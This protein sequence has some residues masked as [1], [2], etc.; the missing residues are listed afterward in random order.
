[1]P[2]N[3]DEVGLIRYKPKDLLNYT[4]GVFEDLKTAISFKSEINSLCYHEYQLKWKDYQL[5]TESETDH[6]DSLSHQYLR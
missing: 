1:M 4:L 2:M 3:V 5:K 6:F